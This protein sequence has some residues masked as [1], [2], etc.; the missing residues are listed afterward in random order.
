MVDGVLRAY[1]NTKTAI[2]VDHGH[3]SYVTMTFEK[4]EQVDFLTDPKIMVQKFLSH[5]HREL[6]QKTVEG[7]LCGGIETTDP[8]F[9]EADSPV[10]SF[11]AR[12]WVSVE[13]GYPVKF[14]GEVVSNNDQMRLAFFS[15]QFQWDVEL[16]ET[17]FEPDIPVDYQD[18]SPG[19]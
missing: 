11:M 13:T 2:L 5:E 3:K 6:D 19:K 15:D 8:A 9:L 12:V 17:M 1:F 10:G 16:D 18:I 4:M 14:E 7:T